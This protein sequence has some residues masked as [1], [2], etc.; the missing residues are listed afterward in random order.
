MGS[1]EFENQAIDV[2]NLLLSND[3]ELINLHR[4]PNRTKKY[5]IY[6]MFISHQLVGLTNE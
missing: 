1:S 3:H 4:I 6:V 2:V 5:A